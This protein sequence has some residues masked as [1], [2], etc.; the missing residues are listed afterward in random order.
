MV[1]VW[2]LVA[3]LV[4]VQGEEEG[5]L[6]HTRLGAVR[7]TFS[8]TEPSS[9]TFAAF[10][11][12]PYAA[13]P[14]GTLRFQPPRSLDTFPGPAP[15][16]ATEGGAACPQLELTGG[17]VTGAEDCLTLNVFSPETVFGRG[18]ARHPVMVW[19]HGRG[20]QLGSASAEMFGPER[21]LEEDLVLVVVQY[22]LGPLGFL[23]TGDEAAP[24]NLGLLDQ[25]LALAWVRDNIAAFAGDPDT[26]TLAGQG[27]GGTSVLAHLASPGSRGLFH[28]GLAMSGVWGEAPGL[29]L[30]RPPAH[31]ARTLGAALGCTE[32][33]SAALVAC[34]QA[35]APGQLLEAAA[36]LREFDFLPEPFKPVVDSWMGGAAVVPAALHEVWAQETVPRLPLLLGGTSE[37]GVLQLLHFLRDPALYA[38]VN[39]DAAR[40]LPALLLGVDPEAAAEDEGE[41]ATAAVLRD[42]YL[43]GSGALAPGAHEEMVKLFTDV[44][45]LSPMEQVRRNA[46]NI[47]TRKKLKVKRYISDSVIDLCT[48]HIFRQ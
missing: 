28:R 5:P 3:W 31:Y 46:T 22:R 33:R 36:Q 24:P 8:L 38:R 15:L 37:E 42:S 34:L 40:L 10:Q 39:E 7:G 25:R 43:P 45:F 47:D 12:I 20:F 44:H 4:P 14:T 29:H 18:A 32:A 27:A 9:R 26:V 30:S 13:P 1:P 21:L 41:A 35:A 17:A 48:L 6:V 11:G 16:R 19:L 23:T 2:V